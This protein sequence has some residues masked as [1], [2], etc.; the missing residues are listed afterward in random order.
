MNVKKYW[1]NICILNYILIYCVYLFNF[2][3]FLNNLYKVNK[4]IIREYRYYVFEDI[5]LINDQKVNK[6]DVL[7]R[8]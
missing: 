5:V 4:C 2:E 3:F 7:L 1:F 8:L 6:V